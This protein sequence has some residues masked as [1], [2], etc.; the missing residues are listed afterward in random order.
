MKIIKNS[1]KE[2]NT[3]VVV[4][5]CLDDIYVLAKLCKSGDLISSRTTRKLFQDKGSGI[6]RITCN[7]EIKAETIDS[8]LQ[9]GI[10]FV[11]GKVSK[12]HEKVAVGVYHSLSIPLEQLMSITKQEWTK[13]DWKILEETKQ[14][15]NI[16]LFVVF[17]EQDC[18]VSQGNQ[19]NI[20]IISKFESKPKNFTQIINSIKMIKFKPEFIVITGTFDLCIQFYNQFK[21]NL[22]KNTMGFKMPSDY[23]GLTNSKFISKLLED[24]QYKHLKGSMGALPIS[25]SV[26]KFISDVNK[27]DEK[28]VLGWKEIKESYKFN[29]LKTVFITDEIYKPIE[30][31]KRRKM[32]RF[33]SAMN[34]ND[35]KVIVVPFNTDLGKSLSEFGGIGARL[36]FKFK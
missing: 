29:A 16:S 27:M 30:I 12:K 31:E 4:P 5:N 21:N 3:L 33:L 8:D 18:V 2:N 28:V 17:F 32:D 9:E 13:N 14:T 11:K 7:L 23:R 6:T 26:E 15:S 20:H 19:N 34:E 24:P 10:L 36:N 22:P 35:I 1:T 25:E